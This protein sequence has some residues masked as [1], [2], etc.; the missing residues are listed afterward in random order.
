[1]V[2]EKQ[3]LFFNLL[4]DLMWN[5]VESTP[6]TFRSHVVYVRASLLLCGNEEQL[7]SVLCRLVEKSPGAKSHDN[8]PDGSDINPP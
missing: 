7:K 8:Q 2:C 3:I 1:M 5:I 6:H 4:I